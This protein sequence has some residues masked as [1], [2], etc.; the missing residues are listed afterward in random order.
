MAYAQRE[1]RR[2]IGREGSKKEPPLDLRKTYKKLSNSSQ[3]GLSQ[4]GLSQNGYGWSRNMVPNNG[5]NK[6]SQAMV[7]QIGLGK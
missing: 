4:N 2:G 7:A 5:L 1:D 6:W 3:D